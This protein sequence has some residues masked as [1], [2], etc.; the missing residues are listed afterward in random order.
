VLDLAG[1][2]RITPEAAARRLAWERIEAAS[3]AG[4]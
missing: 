3:S 4:R 2:E 1:R